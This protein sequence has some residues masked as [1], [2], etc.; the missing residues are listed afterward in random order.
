MNR[1]KIDWCKQPQQYRKPASNKFSS[2]EETFLNEEIQKIIKKGVVE[3]VHTGVPLKP[4]PSSPKRWWMETR[5]QSKTVKQFCP[6][7]SLQNGGNTSSEG[8]LETRG[9]DDKSRSE[10]CLLLSTNLSI[11]QKIPPIP[12]ERPDISVQLPTFWTVMRSLGLYKDNQGSGGNPK[13][14]GHPSNHIHRRHID[15]SRDG[16]SAK[17]PESRPHIPTGKP[18]ICGQPPKIPIT[19][20]PDNRIP[21]IHGRLPKDGAKTSR[22]KDKEYQSRHQQ[23]EN[24]GDSHSSRPLQVS[25][26][27]ELHHTGN[28]GSMVHCFTDSCRTICK[29]S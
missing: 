24:S 20:N 5:N 1:Y 7:P 22:P 19:T 2:A 4:V 6:D 23:A 9:Q 17:G 28:I 3:K 18:G 16:V 14:H 26:E 8:H 13:K 11:G 21:G 29:W 27:A 12:V 25:G 15:N 10:R